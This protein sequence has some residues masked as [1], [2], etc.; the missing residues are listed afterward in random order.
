MKNKTAEKI[1]GQCFPV[2]SKVTCKNLAHL[3][4]HLQLFS[5]V[6]KDYVTTLK[7]FAVVCCFDSEGTNGLKL[8]NIF[9][10]MFSSSEIVSWKKSS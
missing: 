7:L 5:F 2:K 8:E 4:A 9:S 3:E 1:T 10:L 6:T